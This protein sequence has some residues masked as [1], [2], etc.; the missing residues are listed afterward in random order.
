MQA[1]NKY[2]IIEGINEE[3]KS[4]SGMLLSGKD[5]NSFRY[6]KGRVINPGTNVDVIK[7]GDVIHY[8]KGSGHT[9]I[10]DNKQYIIIKEGDVVVV[11]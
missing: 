8:D 11:L 10:L 9:M 1:I 2:I 6:L 4:D 7:A 5:A 3:L